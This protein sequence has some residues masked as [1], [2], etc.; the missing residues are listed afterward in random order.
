MST[1]I[2]V[3][4]LPLATAPRLTACKQRSREEQLA[5]RRRRHRGSSPWSS[6]TPG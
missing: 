4:K 2:T 3:C 6:G 1:T 5:V